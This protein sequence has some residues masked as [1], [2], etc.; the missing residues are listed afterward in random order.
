MAVTM[1]VAIEREKSREDTQLIASFIP[2]PVIVTNSDLARF[3]SIQN[4]D[5]TLT[6]EDITRKTGVI[7]RHYRQALGQ[8]ADSRFETIPKMAE[9]MAASLLAQKS[10]D[11]ATVGLFAVITTYPLGKARMISEEVAKRLNICHAR[12]VDVY[13]GCVGPVYFLDRLRRIGYQDSGKVLAVS[14]EHY[15]PSLDL[16]MDMAVFSDQK[17][18]IAFEGKNL[19]IEDS[20]IILK[21]NRLITFPIDK[22]DYPEGSWVL[23]MPTG[24]RN[25]S[26]KGLEVYE[27]I[28]NGPLFGLIKFLTSKNPEIEALVP[29]P[30]SGKVLDM[31]QRQLVK[32]GSG[33]YVSRETLSQ[34][35]NGA[36][37][38]NFAE[39]GAFLKSPKGKT[40][41]NIILAAAGAGMAFGAVRLLKRDS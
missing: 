20:E 36:A 25:F 15:T 17:S 40:T 16:G 9:E 18:G 11:P 28:R 23:D 7:K 12:T 29:H 10:W 22:E 35:G 13:A 8:E 21:P 26:M 30:G 24:S 41:R 3:L 19:Q 2:E 37:A 5:K 34:F 39:L 38:S 1:S 32:I 33:L 27:A 31:I 6:A 14:V 4:T